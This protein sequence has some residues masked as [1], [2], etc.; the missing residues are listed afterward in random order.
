MGSDNKKR[1]TSNGKKTDGKF[2]SK[3]INHN[4][5]DESAR[6]KFGLQ[7]STSDGDKKTNE[8]PGKVQR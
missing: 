6:T 4:A 5:Q 1:S 8:Y 7:N 3:H 2:H